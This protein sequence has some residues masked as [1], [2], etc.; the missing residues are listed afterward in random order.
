VPSIEGLS[1]DGLFLNIPEAL[2]VYRT[3]IKAQKDIDH[4]RIAYTN[5]INNAANKAASALGRRHGYANKFH[6]EVHDL[7]EYTAPIHDMLFDLCMKAS[8][9]IN[10]L[11]NYQEQAKEL[12]HKEF[13]DVYGQE[14]RA[15]HRIS[16]D[17]ND[18][19]IYVAL[20]SKGITNRAD[21]QIG[22]I[23]KLDEWLISI[24]KYNKDNDVYNIDMN[25]T[26]SR[27]WLR[28]AQRAVRDYHHLRTDLE[29]TRKDVDKLD[30]ASLVR[31]SIHEVFGEAEG[32][33]QDIHYNMKN[34]P[35]LAF[36][37][38]QS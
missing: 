34:W 23:Q 2:K 25:F 6:D 9:Y 27:Y 11:H 18:L 32:R 15:Q 24:G 8:A 19:G 38:P 13:N 14:F 21:I 26:K 5:I 29:H 30:L 37:A 12:Y 33:L 7:L 4:A 3:D 1:V 16:S 31:N 10:T 20:N 36:E 22:T 28:N 17:I 35:E